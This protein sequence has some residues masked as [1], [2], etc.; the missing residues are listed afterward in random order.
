[1]MGLQLKLPDR[2]QVKSFFSQITIEPIFF[3][4]S[5][6]FGLYIV[7][8]KNLYIEKVC[9]VNLNFTEEICDNIQE[10]KEEQILVQQYVSELKVY[11]SVIQAIF[12]CLFALFAGPWSDRHGRRVLII[13]SV[14]GYILCNAVFII[15]THFFYELKAEYLLFECLQGKRNIYVICFPS[16][17]PICFFQI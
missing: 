17:D 14:F 3:L 13:C 2:A 15:N 1:M 6:N 4:F 11:N 10:H 9:K 12:P 8:A 16:L 5:L 7:V